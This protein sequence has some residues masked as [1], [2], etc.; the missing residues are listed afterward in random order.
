MPLEEARVLLAVG[1][2][3]EPWAVR[4]ALMQGGV[5]EPRRRAY[6]ALLAARWPEICA[7]PRADTEPGQDPDALA[8]AHEEELA[9]AG[10]L[11]QA[12]DALR[13]AIADGATHLV[14][15]L[16]AFHADRLTSSELD[17]LARDRPTGW[18]LTCAR[19]AIARGE[20]TRA[21]EI[22]VASLS[23]QGPQRWHAAILLDLL[24]AMADPDAGDVADAIVKSGENDTALR[25]DVASA[26]AVAGLT[27]DPPHEIWRALVAALIFDWPPRAADALS[28]F[29]SSFP[30]RAAVIATTLR[31]VPGLAERFDPWLRPPRQLPHCFA[32]AIVALL[33]LLTLRMWNAASQHDA[34][35]GDRAIGAVLVEGARPV[36]CGGPPEPCAA[37]GRM[38]RMLDRGECDAAAHHERG[39]VRRVADLPRDPQLE[40]L[41]LALR[42]RYELACHDGP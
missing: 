40:A 39:Y 2:Q 24:D 10:H 16:H 21:A 23:E 36:A 5:T 13:S 12:A 41:H 6:R 11:E 20:T 19:A 35:D 9:L 32:L 14:A 37:L 15:V 4:A 29:R 27:P 38:S 34:E 7:S 18:E 25:S 42:E 8:L 28:R 26:I 22:A 31:T 17:Q 33:G 3:A 30:S 1:P